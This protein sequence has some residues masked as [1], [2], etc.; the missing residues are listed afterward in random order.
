MDNQAEK[1]KA[2]AS[3]LAALLESNHRRLDELG[4]AVSR[5]QAE[6]RGLAT[7]SG[8]QIEAQVV[9][10][11]PVSEHLAPL[12]AEQFQRLQQIIDSL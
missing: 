3:C 2:V 5:L 11:E 6:V 9:E 8:D 1:F 7:T 10:I 4:D 12:R